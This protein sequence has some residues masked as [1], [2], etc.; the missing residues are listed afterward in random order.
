MPIL[1]ALG[2]QKDGLSCILSFSVMSSEN[3]LPFPALC[4][5]LLETVTHT[6]WKIW[7]E[8]SSDHLANKHREHGEVQCFSAFSRTWCRQ[9]LFKRAKKEVQ[10]VKKGSPLLLPTQD[11]LAK[12]WSSLHNLQ[13]CL[14]WLGGTMQELGLSYFPLIYP[15]QELK[16]CPTSFLS[17]K[18]SE[19]FVSASSQSWGFQQ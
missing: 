17:T 13:K 12:E 16:I 14:L 8:R 19:L 18:P 4:Y 11:S 9:R 2:A 7:T 10:W 1:S 5:S 3:L 6:L 15:S